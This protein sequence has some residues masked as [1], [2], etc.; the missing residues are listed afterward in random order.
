MSQAPRNTS[1]PATGWQ[2][3]SP[4]RMA[5]DGLA[6]TKKGA[7]VGALVRL[8]GGQHT[9]LVAGAGSGFGTY[10]LDVTSHATGQRSRAPHMR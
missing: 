7:L 1:A 9:R 4:V 8:A 6:K 2:P 3:R 10:C 5:E